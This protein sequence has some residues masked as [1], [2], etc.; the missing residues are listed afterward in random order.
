MAAQRLEGLLGRLGCVA[1]EQQD[2]KRVAA[3][4]GGG[5]GVLDDRASG[6]PRP[7]SGSARQEQA[8]RDESLPFRPALGARAGRRR[9]AA[10]RSDFEVVPWLNMTRDPRYARRRAWSIAVI[11][12]ASSSPRVVSFQSGA[13]MRV[14]R[15]D[16]KLCGHLTELLRAPGS[17]PEASRRARAAR[18]DGARAG[19]GRLRRRESWPLASRGDQGGHRV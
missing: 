6:S 11:V 14:S 10:V 16:G 9:P 12:W 8:E 5:L 7:T 3:Q 17:R 4:S 15:T 1:G 18:A 13:A 19:R 2:L